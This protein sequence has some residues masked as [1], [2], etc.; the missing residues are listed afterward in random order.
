M[1]TEATGTD[2]SWLLAEARRLLDRPDESTAGRWPR[3]AA[4]LARQALETSVSAVLGERAPGAE[5]C[6][7]RA[8]LLCLRQLI[9]PEHAVTVEHAWVALSRACHH[10]VYELP[11]IADELRGWLDVVE[12]LAVLCESGR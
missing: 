8:Q 6:S 5:H 1:S 11:P 3:A 7:A 2:S 4:L 12:E 10:H 9:D